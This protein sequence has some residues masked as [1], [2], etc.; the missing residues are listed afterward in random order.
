MVMRCTHC[1]GEVALLL[2]SNYA[3]SRVQCLRWYHAEQNVNGDLM[4]ISS[5]G[6]HL[7]VVSPAQVMRLR[8]RRKKIRFT[9]D[10]D[11]RIDPNERSRMHEEAFRPP[12]DR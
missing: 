11:K 4:V 7:L 1:G 2:N 3:D 8:E 9:L 6:T 10:T 12:E 5:H